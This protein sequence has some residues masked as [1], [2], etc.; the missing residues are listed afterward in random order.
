[1]PGKLDSVAFS[2][3][4][5][6]G[7]GLQTFEKSF[8]SIVHGHA[9]PGTSLMIMRANPDYG[10]ETPLFPYEINKKALIAF[11]NRIAEKR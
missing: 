11:W 1:M 9:G 4:Q 7:H 3:L 5:N 10:H 6:F 2:A 8:R